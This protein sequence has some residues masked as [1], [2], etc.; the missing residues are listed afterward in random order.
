MF[1]KS[2]GLDLAEEAPSEEES[3]PSEEQRSRVYD[4]LTDEDGNSRL[5]HKANVPAL[6]NYDQDIRAPQGEVH[7]ADKLKATKK[8]AGI[9]EMIARECFEKTGR[10][11]DVEF[12]DTY[13]F[14]K[15]PTYVAKPDTVADISANTPQLRDDMLSSRA[16]HYLTN[17]A[18]KARSWSDEIPETNDLT[19]VSPFPFDKTKVVAGNDVVSRMDD[20]IDDPYELPEEYGAAYGAIRKLISKYGTE[21]VRQAMIMTKDARNNDDTLGGSENP[22]DYLFMED[23]GPRNSNGPNKSWVDSN[24]EQIQNLIEH[25]RKRIPK[26]RTNPRITKY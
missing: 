25:D 17:V 26:E 2:K 16:N 12:M 22:F 21:A 14:Q 15:A 6:E 5:K 13:Q 20:P 1:R 24:A 4:K 7:D 23:R 11:P 18:A 10:I 8:S 19:P 9:R 3:S